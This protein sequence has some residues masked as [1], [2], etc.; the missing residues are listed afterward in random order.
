MSLRPGYWASLPSLLVP[1]ANRKEPNPFAPAKG[2]RLAGSFI[3]WV[4]L[5]FTGIVLW[6]MLSMTTQL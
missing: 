1:E 2:W 5:A 6:L 4:G 3:V